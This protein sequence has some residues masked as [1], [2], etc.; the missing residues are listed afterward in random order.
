MDVALF[1]LFDSRRAASFAALATASFDRD[2]S[3]TR[4]PGE[5]GTPTAQA[6]ESAFGVGLV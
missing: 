5:P 6:A 3:R 1:A 2:L 4:S